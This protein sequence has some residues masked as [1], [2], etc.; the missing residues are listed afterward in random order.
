MRS[1][2]FR[3]AS[4]DWL[5]IGVALLA[6]AFVAISLWRLRRRRLQLRSWLGALVLVAWVV[7]VGV[8]VHFDRVREARVDP[9]LAALPSIAWPGSTPDAPTAQLPKTTAASQDASQTVEAAPIS[10]LIG[11]LEQRLA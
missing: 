11:G 5:L 9:R 1:D 4:Y 10:S 6:I 2:L 8:K 7:G 3:S